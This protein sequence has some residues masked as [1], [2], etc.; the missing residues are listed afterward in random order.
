[1]THRSFL[2]DYAIDIEKAHKAVEK[3][4]IA[5]SKGAS[6]DVVNKANRALADAMF[7][8]RECTGTRVHDDRG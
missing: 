1:M 7:R 5:Y 6:P 2:D 3:A 4:Q 8:D